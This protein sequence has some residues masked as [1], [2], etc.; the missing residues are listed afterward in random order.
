MFSAQLESWTCHNSAPFD[1]MLAM[2]VQT[3]LSGIPGD[4]HP[5]GRGICPLR[6]LLKRGYAC[7]ADCK[8]YSRASPPEVTE[9]YEVLNELIESLLRRKSSSLMDMWQCHCASHLWSSL[10]RASQGNCKILILEEEMAGIQI[11][12]FNQADLH[13][14]PRSLLLSEKT[15]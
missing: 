12:D 14:W 8:S 1:I 11:A 3:V 6:I 4:T 13:A 2:T 10:L 7:K 15:F 9:I 5:S